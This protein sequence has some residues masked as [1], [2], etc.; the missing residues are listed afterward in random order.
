MR[1]GIVKL[2]G[3]G[4]TFVYARYARKK[5]VKVVANCEETVRDLQ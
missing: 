5:I 2:S 3:A 1:A 4:I